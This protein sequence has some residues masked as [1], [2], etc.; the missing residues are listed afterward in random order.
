MPGSRQDLR[1]QLS[2]LAFQQAG[3]FTAAQALDVGYSYQ[4]Q[5]YHVDHGNWV[6]VQ[7]ALFRL[8]GWPSEATDAYARWSVWSRDRGVVSHE[9]AL[10][11][12]DLSDVNPAQIHMTV[13]ADFRASDSAV[14]LH[15]GEVPSDDT[16]QR[17]GWRVTAP[18]RTL[19]DVAG[20]DT[21]IEFVE[22]AVADAL[23]R[24]LVTPRRLSSGAESRGGRAAKRLPDVLARIGVT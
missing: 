18:L 15:R 7:R 2:A 11:V 22:D 17:P 24:G 12:Y 5:K 1:Q 13:P 19:I 4:A 14:V 23:E 6:R 10:S 9:S 20:S 16:E 21:P 3:Y 8:P